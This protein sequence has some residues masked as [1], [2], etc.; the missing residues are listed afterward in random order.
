M[1]E[2]VLQRL[3]EWEHLGTRT[4]DNGSRLVAHTPRDFPE[5]YLHAYF[6]P[7]SED[8]WKACKLVLPAP[9]QQ[10]Y[11][12]CNGLYL[13]AGSLALYGIRA[14]YKRDD[15]AQFQPFDLFTHHEEDLLNYRKGLPAGAIFFG[16][17][18]KEGSPIY[19]TPDDPQVHRVLRRSA[20]VVNSWPDLATFLAT[21]YDRLDRLFSRAG[22]LLDPKTPT[23][24]QRAV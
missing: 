11:R 3:Q 12:E 8:R 1:I 17:Y 14:H 16:S 13:F 24:P 19:M 18:V 5:A 20:R 2:H 4:A 9:L 21:E 10:L 23:T 15:S 22:Y 6:A 7:V